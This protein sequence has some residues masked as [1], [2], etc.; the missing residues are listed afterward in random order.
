[1]LR[2]QYRFTGLM[3][4]ETK[5]YIDGEE[6]TGSVLSERL[7]DRIGEDNPVRVVESSAKNL[8]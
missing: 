6:R 7:D 5:R 8:T 3:E 2:Q 1:M 4:R